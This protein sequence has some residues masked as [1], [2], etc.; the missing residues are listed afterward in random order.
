MYLKLKL[1]C[2]CSC[3][4]E[5]LEDTSVSEIICPNCGEKMD[6]ETSD[7]LLKTLS[8]VNSIENDPNNPFFNSGFNIS[9]VTSPFEE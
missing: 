3:T 5:L 2:H 4:H 8:L 6:K 1:K 7:K 9:L